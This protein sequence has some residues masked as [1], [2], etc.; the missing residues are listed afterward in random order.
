VE[1]SVTFWSESPDARLCFGETAMDIIFSNVA[2]FDV[3]QKN[4]FVCV[5]QVQ[6]AGQRVN[7]PGA[8]PPAGPW[9]ETN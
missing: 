3:H 8:L 7:E 6:A 1:Q 5:R 2:G 9:V 4:V